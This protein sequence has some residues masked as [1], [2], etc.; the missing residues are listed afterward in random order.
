M[1]LR[2]ENSDFLCHQKNFCNFLGEFYGCE[3]KV[4]TAPI[5]G[6]RDACPLR[7]ALSFASSPLRP[8]CLRLLILGM[9]LPEM[10]DRLNV[11]FFLDFFFFDECPG[12]ETP[13]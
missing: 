9:R 11:I 3:R 13:P 10:R 8:C 12:M 2:S 6:G 7:C 5:R 1:I 4:A